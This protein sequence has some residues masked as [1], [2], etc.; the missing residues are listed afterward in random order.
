MV[1]GSAL[2]LPS[3]GGLTEMKK[4]TVGAPSVAPVRGY[5]EHAIAGIKKGSYLAALFCTCF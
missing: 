3:A 1:H 5:A 4:S 2:S